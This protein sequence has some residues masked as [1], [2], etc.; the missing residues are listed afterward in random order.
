MSEFGNET[1]TAVFQMYGK[2][3]ELL[4]KLLKHITETQ[5]RRLNK[6][7]RKAEVA[8]LRKT[9]SIEEA[10]DYLNHTRGLVKAKYMQD[11]NKELFPISQP[12]S[13]SELKRFNRLATTYGLNYFT[14]QN[15]SVLDKITG[16]K[17]ELKELENIQ[18]AGKEKAAAEYGTTLTSLQD[19]YAALQTEL[20]NKAFISPSE[21]K[22]LNELKDEIEQIEEKIN[23]NVLSP[24]QLE[25][26]GLL[27]K[28]LETL[29]NQRNDVIVVVFKEDLA[30]VNNITE[31]MNMEIDLSDINREI[32]SIKE[33][34][35]LS[36]ADAHRLEELEKEKNDIL[37]NEFNQF[38][39]ENAELIVDN[40]LDKDAMAEEIESFS[41]DKAIGRACD[42]EYTDAPCYVCDRNNPNNYIEAKSIKLFNEEG[43]PYNDTSFTIY[44]NG[45]KMDK[46][47]HRQATIDGRQTSERGEQVWSE[48]KSNIKSQGGFSDDLVIFSNKEDYE[49]YKQAYE[50][51]KVEGAEEI[52]KEVEIAKEEAE[53]GAVD[54]IPRN[55]SYR[56]YNGMAK[57]LEEQL[58][59]KG[60]ALNENGE[61]CHADTLKELDVERVNSETERI[62]YAEAI[63]IG[64]QIGVL[65][66]LNDA[67]TQVAF[68]ENQQQ[69]NYENFVKNG[70]P[71]SMREMYTTMRET[72]HK[73][74]HDILMNTAVLGSKLYRLEDELNDLKS[75]VIVDGIQ[76]HNEEI[77]KE[78]EKERDGK[79]LGVKNNDDL[80]HREE[81]MQSKKQWAQDM[82]SKGEMKS[83]A[84]APQTEKTFEIANERE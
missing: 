71:E 6:Q 9:S 62:S 34:D 58:A 14:M 3:G 11:A 59:A 51:A 13:P 41:F 12:M 23:G 56:D 48:I 66:E 57:Q 55:K 68:I 36:E 47:Y 75:V 73:Q 76:K 7:L 24:A 15:E 45:E 32:E 1:A 54:E 49:A 8:K 40:A 28:Q 67:Q 72:L 39:N 10:R 5:E 53:K 29:N 37:R 38:N 80:T 83:N 22:Q 84:A 52:K 17:A 43:L 25:R 50:K 78:H 26:K 79:T 82:Q 65:K 18:A 27:E 70:K 20:D 35:T 61:V 44:H 46:E 4:F 42:R 19:R 74:S 60:M 2:M 63:N 69:I 31:R 64:K 33:K 77:A 21:R 16:V 81:H 30:I